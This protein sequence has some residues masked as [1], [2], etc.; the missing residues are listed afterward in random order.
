MPIK[1]IN[2]KS[3]ILFSM[4]AIGF[5]PGLFG[6][7]SIYVW[8]MDIFQQSTGK[9]L[10]HLVHQIAA[11]IRTTL[12]KEASEGLL[13]TQHPDVRLRVGGAVDER[14]PAQL[15]ASIKEHFREGI[16]HKPYATYFIYNRTG[17]L[18]LQLGPAVDTPPTADGLEAALRDISANAV[19]GEPVNSHTSQGFY[20]PLFTP[21]YEHNGTRNIIGGMVT[22]LNIPQLLGPIQIS[23]PLE[24]GHFNLLTKSGMLIY[25]PIVPTGNLFFP[26]ALTHTLSTGMKPWDI[27]VDEHGIE[28][29]YT[30]TPLLLS[31]QTGLTYSGSDELYVAIT[32][33]AIDAFIAPTRS[34]LIGAALPGFILAILLTLT[35]YLVLKKLVNPI[36]TLKKGASIIGGGNLDHRI[37]VQ[38]ADEIEDLADEFNKMTM[39]LK[40]S[41]ADLEKKIRERT[42]KLEAFNQELEK[43]SHLKSQF[44]ASMSHELRT[45]L[46][47][48]MGFSEVL[49]EEVYGE[50]NEK[51]RRYLNNIY[52][53]GK[54]LLEVIND[55][56]DLSKI[57]AGKMTLHLRE[58]VVEDAIAEVHNLTLQLASKAKVELCF[59]TEQA[60]DLIIADCVRF[61][62][63]MYNLLSNAIK[64]TPEGGRITV[65]AKQ[66][67][68]HLEVSVEDTGIGIPYEHIEN[69]FK[70]FRQVDGSSS[71]N[72]E[73]TGLGL[74]LTKEFIEMH[75]GHISVS[76]RQHQ[77]SC[78]TFSIP[79]HTP[80]TFDTY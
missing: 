13:I 6:I 12:D 51:Q 67:G 59:H 5:I 22:Y 39:A 34:M 26:T 72:Y 64:F 1:R 49:T 10:T 66:V 35:I 69:I 43:A 24:A 77:G 58:L 46:N 9:S 16:N 33:P 38:T 15:D 70:P 60:P 61:R 53:S 52:K 19:V 80:L 17:E 45:P 74:A 41:Y 48:I 36:H 54:H 23:N 71:R 78:F 37:E 50:I 76:S 75:G 68:T 73:G 18:L 3:K 62:Q 44:L 47:A 29:L 42:L 27:E 20:I 32:Q 57:E 25:D 11:N 31:Y 56:L 2:I 79:I 55:I 21:I 4:L 65:T 40:S 28:S 30:A 63:I 7:A 8:G 14:G